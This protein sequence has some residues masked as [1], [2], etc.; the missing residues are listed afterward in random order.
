MGPYVDNGIVVETDFV[1]AKLYVEGISYQNDDLS[2]CK[3]NCFEEPKGVNCDFLLRSVKARVRRS[4]RKSRPRQ[5]KRESFQLSV[6]LFPRLPALLSVHPT[7]QPLTG[8]SFYSSVR[9]V[10]D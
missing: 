6:R 7:V 1:V 10:D 5:S 8:L 9:S 3:E 2:V 4:E